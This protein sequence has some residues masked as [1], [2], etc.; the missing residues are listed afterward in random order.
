MTKISDSGDLWIESFQGPR[1]S[2]PATTAI[3]TTFSLTRPGHVVG[4]VSSI[5]STLSVANTNEIEVTV[6]KTDNSFYNY[7]D[8]I[9]QVEAVKHNSGLGANIFGFHIIV[10][11]KK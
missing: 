1:V 2:V 6:R 7:G 11:L 5:D 10:F 8:A 4:I 9:T 3:A